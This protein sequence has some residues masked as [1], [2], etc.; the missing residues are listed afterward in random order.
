MKVR[1]THLRMSC[2]RPV[3]LEIDGGMVP[4][5]PLESR[6][7]LTSSHFAPGGGGDGKEWEG[8]G[9]CGGAHCAVVL[10]VARAV[11]SMRSMRSM[12]WGRTPSWSIFGISKIGMK[13]ETK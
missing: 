12:L 6:M 3:I 10:V 9:G 11:R 5:R 7:M 8:C 13:F 4:V 2:T 1:V